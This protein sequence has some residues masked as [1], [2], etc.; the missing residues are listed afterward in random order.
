MQHTLTVYEVT[1]KQQQR[2]LS[3]LLGVRKFYIHVETM[4][5]C[6]HKG[7]THI[8]VT[9]YSNISI[10]GHLFQGHSDNSN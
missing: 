5:R 9:R 1:H 10:T 8:N 2:I 7:N 6:Q 4:M 3:G